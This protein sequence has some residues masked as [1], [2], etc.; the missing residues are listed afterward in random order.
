[1]TL[2]WIHTHPTQTCFLSSIDL[3]THF[4]YQVMLPEAI[5]IVMAPTSVPDSGIFSLSKKGMEVLGVSDQR[6]VRQLIAY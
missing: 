6:S 3:H 5:A 2:G 1:L 4:S